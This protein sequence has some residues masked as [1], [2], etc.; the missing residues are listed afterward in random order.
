MCSE[1]LT[2]E[3]AEEE[4]QKKVGLRPQGVCS[5]DLAAEIAEEEEQ[6]KLGL[7]PEP[8]SPGSPGLDLTLRSGPDAEIWT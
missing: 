7:R 1:D 4:E 2:A 8:F 3:V 6:K 5:E